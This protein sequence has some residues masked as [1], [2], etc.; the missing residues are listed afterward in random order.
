MSGEDERPD[1]D[2]RLDERTIRARQRSRAIV[3]G[4]ILGGLVVLFYAI[5]IAKMTGGN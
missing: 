2:G 1:D 3:T 4:L 5:A